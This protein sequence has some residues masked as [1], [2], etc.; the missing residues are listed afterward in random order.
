MISLLEIKTIL[1]H[2]VPDTPELKS[3]STPSRLPEQTAIDPGLALAIFL[4]A[5]G[6]LWLFRRYTFIEPDEGIIL[7]GAQR[8]L[9]GE[10]L[11]RDFFSFFTPGS[12]YF[13]AL[14]F[15]I[16][17]SSIIVAR[18][19]LVLIGAAFSV[20]TY[21]SM[22]VRGWHVRLA[23]IFVRAIQGRGTWP[24]PRLRPAGG[25]L[26]M[27]TNSANRC[28]DSPATRPRV[29]FRHNLRVFCRA[30]QFGN[31]V[32]R[33]VL[34]AAALLARQSRTLRIPNLVL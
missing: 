24:R 20:I 27:A 29:A 8:I 11:Y 28:T 22:G 12:Y 25:P 6:Y 32:G 31:H 7:Q 1:E 13:V 3:A 26:G 10:V 33:L 21:L 23:H 4:L 19:A 17:G 14:I 15:K 9:R 34:A 2:T 5:V 18:T 30:A 16:F